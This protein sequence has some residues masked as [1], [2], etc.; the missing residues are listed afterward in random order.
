[1]RVM[2]RHVLPNIF[3]PIRVLVTLDMGIVLLEISGL[4]FLG[5]GVSPPTPEW[6]AMLSEGRTYLSQ[7]PQM[8]LFPGLAIFLLVLG[9]NL[10]GDGLRD[11]FDPQTRRLPRGRRRWLIAGPRA[12]PHRGRRFNGS[13]TPAVRRRRG[14]GT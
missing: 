7:A 5:L 9:F 8:M 1:L 11:A 14:V 12:G 6:G 3:A 13:P 2:A 10:L 4:S